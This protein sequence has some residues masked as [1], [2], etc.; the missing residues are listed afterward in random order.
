MTTLLVYSNIHSESSTLD[1][2]GNNID[3]KEPRLIHYFDRTTVHVRQRVPDPET[4]SSFP[5][6]RH[7]GFETGDLSIGYL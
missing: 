5:A 4:L 2:P 1:I 7:E 6:S 3:P